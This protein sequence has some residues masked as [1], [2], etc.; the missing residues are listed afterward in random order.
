M[1]V[2]ALAF[3]YGAATFLGATLLAA[4]DQRP[5][6]ITG[7]V[8]DSLGNVLP[9]VEVTALKVAKSVRTDTAGK[10]VLAGLPNGNMDVTF[11]RL[12]YE[13]IALMIQVPPDDTTDVEVTL[14]VVAQKLTGVVVQAAPDHL[15]ELFAFETRR[16]QGMGHFITRKQIEQRSPYL[17]SDMMRTVPGVILTPSPDGRAFLHFSRIPKANCAPQYYVDGIQV[18]AFNID[19]MPAH[20]V[21]GVELYP[22]PAG[23]PPEYN[24]VMSNV[25][26]GTVI[27][28]TRIPGNDKSDKKPT[29]P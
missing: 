7:V 4:Q 9:N 23:L 29:E 8:K 20:D 22:G 27:I 24:R 21:E 2:R 12:A 1:R 3:A 25:F 15:R 11:R 6:A 14:G 19:D 18:T 10:F 28:W 17:L 26:C 5:G 13:P 16:K